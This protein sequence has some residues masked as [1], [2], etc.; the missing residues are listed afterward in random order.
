[1]LCS[2]THLRTRPI[3]AGQ[4]RAFDGVARHLNFRAA[5]E[6]V[7]L[8][9]SAVSRQIQALEE[10]VGAVLFHRHTRSVELTTA[11]A[12]LL[13]AVSQSLPRMDAA[14]RQIRQCAGRQGVSISTFASFASMWLIPR[15]ERFQR[16]N[17]NID[18]RIDASDLPV[19]LE[20]ADVDL[21]L[22]T[23]HAPTSR[24]GSA[25]VRRAAHA[26]GQPVVARGRW[27]YSARQTDGWRASR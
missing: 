5:S 24:A 22:A 23:A 20:V 16:D 13:A 7:A 18:I 19:E 8:T 26:G 6:E 14:V 17:P 11:G 2:Q 10:D 25:A 15:L 3:A 1:M 12:L 9:Q 27:R 4:L 21:A